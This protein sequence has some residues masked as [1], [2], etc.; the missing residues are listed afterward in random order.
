M[1]EPKGDP[2]G[3][4]QSPLREKG[5]D[6]EDHVALSK[7]KSQAPDQFRDHPTGDSAQSASPQAIRRAADHVCGSLGRCIRNNSARTG[8]RCRARSG[9]VKAT[10]CIDRSSPSQSA[11]AGP[12]AWPWE[13][14]GA[15]CGALHSRRFSSECFPKPS[16]KVGER[17]GQ[18]GA[19]GHQH[20]AATLGQDV[21]IQAK[22][23]TH[24][25]FGAVAVDSRAHPSGCDKGC[26]AQRRT[27]AAGFHPCIKK[28]AL[29]ACAGSADSL[30]IGG[31][32]QV[33]LAQI[34]HCQRPL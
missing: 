2:C 10:M 25:A 8:N 20:Q 15:N 22:H 33:L 19:P 1:L 34:A 4:W 29:T 13:L 14:Q 24:T 31:F 16:L 21:L 26:P 7:H 5:G 11:P 30:K 23:F 32:A 12:P 17:G 9:A 28:T 27:F 3:L 18:N 6:A